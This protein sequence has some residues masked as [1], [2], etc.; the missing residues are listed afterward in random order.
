MSDSGRGLIGAS[1][2]RKQSALSESEGE[3]AEMT[4]I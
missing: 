2:L 4:M 1:Y 3:E